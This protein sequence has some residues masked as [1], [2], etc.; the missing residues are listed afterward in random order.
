MFI[1]MTDLLSLIDNVKIYFAT[2][3]LPRLNMI[4]S[5]GILNADLYC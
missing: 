4:S 2:R 3:L 5:Y 1:F